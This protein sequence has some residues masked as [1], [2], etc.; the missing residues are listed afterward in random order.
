MTSPTFAGGG[1]GL[2]RLGRAPAADPISTTTLGLGVAHIV[3]QAVLPAGDGGEAVHLL[4]DDAGDG[5]VEAVAR[6]PRLERRR[7]FAP[8]P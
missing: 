6:L 5:I 7:G 1:E 8:C 2:D 3:E 4:L